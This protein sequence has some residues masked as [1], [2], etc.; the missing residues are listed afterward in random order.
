MNEEEEE[1]MTSAP[2]Q[3]RFVPRFRRQNI[4]VL[5]E[6]SPL[7]RCVASIQGKPL[8]QARVITAYKR[9]GS[10]LWIWWDGRFGWVD[11]SN[12]ESRGW[13]A[14]QVSSFD[15]RESFAGDNFIAPRGLFVLGPDLGG[16]FATNLMTTVPSIIVFTSTVK[17]FP[18]AAVFKVVLAYLYAT[19]TYLLWRAALTEPGILPRNPPDAKPSLPAGCEDAPDLKICHTCNLVRPA[20]SKHCGSCNNCVELFDHHCPWLGTCVARRNY[21]WFSLFLMSEV[22]LIIYVAFVTALRFR[23]EYLKFGDV[24]RDFAADL[25]EHDP[26]PLAAL[27]VA[28]ALSFPVISLLAFHWRL[29]AIA[30]TTN[31]SVRGVY[32]H[33]SNRNNLGC[34][35]NCANAALNLCRHT[36]PSRILHLD[37]RKP[38]ERDLELHSRCFYGTCPS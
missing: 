33:H 6:P 38:P 8:G 36:P 7:S 32:R 18:H 12:L 13:R 21:A 34:R 10:W 28:V 19:T 11:L 37:R 25:V 30:Q 27:A 29:A 16:F 20:R 2:V 9:Q 1:D 3:F 26:W 17:N 22:I 23:A 35:A 24:P 4:P 31:E 14:S 5:Q 15:P